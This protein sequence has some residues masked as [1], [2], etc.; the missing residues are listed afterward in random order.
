MLTHPEYADKPEGNGNVP[1]I[2]VGVAILREPVTGVTVM[3]LPPAG[4]LDEL[5]ATG[6][7]RDGSDRARFT[8]VGYGAVLGD[9]P[10][11][12]LFPPD[13]LRRN[14]QSAYREFHERWLFL[15][16]NGVFDLGG[17]GV[18]D[19]GGPALWIDP[20]TAAATL[21]AITSRGNVAALDS[22]CRIDIPE[23]LDFLREVI[24]RVEDGEL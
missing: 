18:G 6:Q 21:V 12:V 4:F 19:S 2:D 3:P 23:V 11:H 7:L 10:N 15:D 8:V 24:E 14:T 13:G 5:Q 1:V 22:K 9:Q 20:A 17:A 16:S